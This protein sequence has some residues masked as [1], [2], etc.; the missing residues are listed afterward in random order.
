[1]AHWLQIIHYND[2]N[3]ML[4]RKVKKEIDRK[5]AEDAEAFKDKRR[6]DSRVAYN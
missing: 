6:E 4:D 1:V 3:K 5:K 2:H